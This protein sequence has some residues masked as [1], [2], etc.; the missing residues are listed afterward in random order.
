M[1]RNHTPNSAAAGTSASRARSIAAG[2]LALAAALLPLPASAMD[3]S[4]KLRL[5]R[6]G[7]LLP[8]PAIPYLDSMR[9][10]S[11][12]PSAPLFKVD[13]LLLPDS[14]QPG[15]FRIPPEEPALPRTS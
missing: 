5:D 14:A 4:P 3:S 6:T 9:W 1:T 15:L 2:A 8:L 10:M 7:N 11:W 13:T 12:K